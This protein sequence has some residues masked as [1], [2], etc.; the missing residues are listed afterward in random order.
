MDPNDRLSVGIIGLGQHMARA[1]LKFLVASSMIDRITWSDPNPLAFDVVR[2]SMRGSPDI[3]IETATTEAILAN[4]QIAAVFIGSPDQYHY[5]QLCAAVASGKHVFCEKP[6]GTSVREIV[7]IAR[8]LAAARSQNLEV[9]TCHPRRF[10]QPILWLI[11]EMQSGAIE[12][13]VGKI[14]RFEFNFWYHRPNAQWKQDRSLLLDH[15]GHEI[16]L[17]RFL[18]PILDQDR[19]TALCLEDSFDAYRVGVE[20]KEFECHFAGYRRLET[21]DFDETIRLVGT[22]GAISLQL[23]NGLFTDERHGTQ[24][25]FPATDYDFR[26]YEVTKNFVLAA[27][28]LALPYL[29]HRDLVIN[30]MA[31]ACLHELGRYTYQPTP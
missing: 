7:D 16:D 2:D 12:R 17:A 4:P 9:S 28:G 14:V 26:H 1:H 23:T 6:I 30:H 31:A 27:A 11:G 18:F 22:T 8:V 13:H 10:D 3:C 21:E 24:F 25:V 20:A 29:T 15:F 5:A 19:W